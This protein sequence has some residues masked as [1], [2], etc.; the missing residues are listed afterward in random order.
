MNVAL[1]CEEQGERGGKVLVWSRKQQRLA[2]LIAM[3]KAVSI[4]GLMMR[5][6][7]MDAT[8]SQDGQPR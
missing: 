5:M 6:R 1:W 2:L 8:H 4:S 7:S 3:V